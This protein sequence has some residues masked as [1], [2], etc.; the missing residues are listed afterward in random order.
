MTLKHASRV[1]AYPI[2]NQ[3]NI[4]ARAETEAARRQREVQYRAL[5][6]QAPD[7]ILVAAPDGR[8]LDANAQA[9]DL[10]D[11]T[12][13][14]LH[15]RTIADVIMVSQEQRVSGLAALRRGETLRGEREARRKD[16]TSVAVETSER[17]PDDGRIQTIL[18]DITDRLTAMHH[19]S[20]H[21]SPDLA[22]VAA[23]PRG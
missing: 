2:D 15:A 13:E 6:D 18:R 23:N 9:L 21:D 10:L 19:T 3:L 5:F 14:E 8:Y 20:H 1:E 16:G 7:A 11:Y 22:S 12:R 17:M 4:I